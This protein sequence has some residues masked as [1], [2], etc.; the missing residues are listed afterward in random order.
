LGCDER[1]S[2]PTLQHI[3]PTYTILSVFLPL[4][5][6]N[7]SPDYLK[8]TNY[9]DPIYAGPTACGDLSLAIFEVIEKRHPS[10]LL[11]QGNKTSGSKITVGQI[12]TLL[13]ELAAMKQ[14]QQTNTS[15]LS[16]FRTKRQ[17]RARWVEKLIAKN[18][19][20]LEHK[21]IVRILLQKL[22]VGIGSESML[23]YYH[24]WATDIYSANKNIRTLCATLCDPEFVRRKK[25][26]LQREVDAVENHNR[27]H[28]L[29]Q[30]HEPATLNSTIAPMLS[31]RTSFESF[32][33]DIRKRHQAYTNALDKDDPIRR[34]LALKFPS[35]VS[36]IK[37][38]GERILAHVKRGVVTMQVKSF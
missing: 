24:P 22:E 10:S 5:L 13:D 15:S 9:N 26:Q 20:P 35:F 6:N 2:V 7:N 16:L 19:S 11:S 25:E 14:K 28:H 33:S 4:G 38:D 8:L 1:R 29:P 21:W 3:P 37:L 17:M 12:N 36:E 23:S 34:S 32:L 31:M 30:S 27:T 18:L